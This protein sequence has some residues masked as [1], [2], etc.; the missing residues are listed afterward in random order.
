[1]KAT[2]TDGIE[3]NKAELGAL[4]DFAG[5]GDFAAVNFR[6]DA[7]QKLI[8]RAGDGKRSIKCVSS[9]GDHERGE[10][11]VQASYL[12][13]VRL[14]IKKGQTDAALRVDSKGLK[15]ALIRGVAS[16]EVQHE[17]LDRTNGT[18]TQVSIE[19]LEELAKDPSLQGSWFALQPKQINRSLAVLSKAADGC[20]VTYYPPHEATGLLLL[21]CTAESGS[22]WLA[23]LPTALVEAPGGEADEPEEDDTPGRPA[24]ASKQPQLP[25]TEEPADEEDDEDEEDGDESGVVDDSYA[26]KLK[27][28]K[29]PKKKATKKAAKKKGRKKS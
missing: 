11:T 25:G 23:T 22:R 24:K 8:V 17:I 6:V 12:E 13:L 1:M 15:D 10:W 16:R 21:E 9:A 18:S 29:S 3:I 26:E 7:K 4:L 2:A 28:Q 14:G 19:Q 27:T 20:P 5:K